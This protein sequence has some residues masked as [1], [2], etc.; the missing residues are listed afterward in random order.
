M[1]QVKSALPEIYQ[2]RVRKMDENK[3]KRKRKTGRKEK[4]PPDQLRNS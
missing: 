4:F 1:E 2:K 3:G